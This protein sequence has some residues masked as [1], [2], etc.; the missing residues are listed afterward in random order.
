MRLLN[1]ER[2]NFKDYKEK[3]DKENSNVKDNNFLESTDA[4]V[5]KINLN[6]HSTNNQPKKFKSSTINNILDSKSYEIFAKII[7]E[8]DKDSWRNIY[9]YGNNNKE[10]C[11]AL[12]IY[13][14]N[15]WK[16]HFRLK[17]NKNWNEGFDFYIPEKFRKFNNEISIKTRVFDKNDNLI[18]QHWVNN[19]YIGVRTIESSVINH[20]SNRF[21][22]DKRPMA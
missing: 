7:I 1:R 22:L 14:N 2:N 15:P 8:S 21:F 11:P 9:H 17:T 19:I 16:F 20:L 4:I 13:P 3:N 6:V 12:W 5:S 18:I 10:R